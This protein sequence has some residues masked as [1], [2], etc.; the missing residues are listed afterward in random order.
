MPLCPRCFNPP[1]ACEC[2]PPFDPATAPPRPRRRAMDPIDADRLVAGLTVGRHLRLKGFLDHLASQGCWLDSPDGER[3]D[4]V[5]VRPPGNFGDARLCAI[6]RST[7]RIE[8]QA[9]S[10]A[11]AAAVGV[12]AS[13]DH[14]S[15]GDKAAINLDTDEDLDAA[16][17]LATAELARRRGSGW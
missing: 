6:S 8:F 2:D 3:S 10:Y 13:M 11:T 16:R 12:A 1:A 15:H 9:D 5:N 17:R 14:L 4:Y 7:G